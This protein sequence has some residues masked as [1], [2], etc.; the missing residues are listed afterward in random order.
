VN[1][2]NPVLDLSSANFG[3]STGTNTPRLIQL[4]L[5]IAF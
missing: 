5:R 1:L 2:N 3:K 4:G